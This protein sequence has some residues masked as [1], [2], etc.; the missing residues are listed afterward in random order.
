M[1]IARLIQRIRSVTWDAFRKGK[2]GSEGTSMTNTTSKSS[3]A[4][5]SCRP[6]L[7]EPRRARIRRRWPAS[8][9][10]EGTV[11]GPPGSSPSEV[12][13]GLLAT[14]PIMP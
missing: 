12:P 8:H 5:G 7:G 10:P 3:G 13:S 14:I 1:K 9:S 6:P 4:Q 2:G 11:P